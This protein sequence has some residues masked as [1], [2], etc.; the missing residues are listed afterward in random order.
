MDERFKFMLSMALL[1]TMALATQ[2]TM[3]EDR[4]QASTATPEQQARPPSP[5]E[6]APA[7]PQQE[8]AASDQTPKPAADVGRAVPS[9]CFNG[10]RD[11]EESDADC[12]GPCRPCAYGKQCA[13]AADCAQDLSCDYRGKRCLQR[14]Y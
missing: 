6:P 10:F 4:A 11:G 3:P 7:S 1:L 13:T 8:T 14:K 2:C 9:T 12:G 5:P